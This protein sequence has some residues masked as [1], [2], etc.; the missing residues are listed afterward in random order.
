MNGDAG[1]QARQGNVATARLALASVALMWS[2]PFLQPRHYLPLPGFYSE[3]LAFA[4]GLG[5]LLLLAGRRAWAHGEFPLLACAPLALAALILLQAAGGRVPYAGQAVGATLY[6]AWAAALIALGAELKRRLGLRAVAFVLAAALVVGGLLTAAAG[7]LQHYG[8][9]ARY[10]PLVWRAEGGAVYGNLSQRNQYAD[11]L[12]LALAAC[13]YLYASGRLRGWIA[14]AVGALLVHGLVLSASRAAWLYV[15]LMLG[16]ALY[17]RRR[18]GTADGVRLLRCSG[19]IAA[20][21]VADQLAMTLVGVRETAADRMLTGAGFD[22]RLQILRSGLDMFL[23]SPLL[24]TGWGSYAWLDFERRAS[25]AAP[26]AL[27]V[28][29]NAH[30]LPL[31]LLAETGLAGAA[32]GLAAAVLWWRDA[33]AGE[34]DVEGCWL[35]LLIGI[36]GLHSMLEFPLWQSY[37]LGVAA[38]AAGLGAQRSL[39]LPLARVAPLGLAVL[40]AAGAVNAGALAY[41]YRQLEQ[42]SAVG[43]RDR[44]AQ[45]DALVALA[46]RELLLRPVTELAIANRM[47]LNGDFLAEKLALNAR[48]MRFF[49]APMVVFR[50]AVL[51][52]L[53]GDAAGAAAWFSRAAHAYPDALPEALAALRRLGEAYPAQIAPLLELASAKMPSPAV[54]AP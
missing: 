51:L 47:D 35:A 52:A 53:S 38:I 4:L 25:L 27:G 14:A 24:G 18:T 13:A 49:P 44:L 50:Q 31:H 34:P 17:Y 7:M 30:N 54:P 8:L 23:Q 9:D 37:F 48:V 19:W 42:L 41:E 3:W 33:W 5:A 39:T 21:L 28:T 11:Y 32:I 40:L 12:A 43:R 1:A 22:A 15:A 29:N 36:I 10:A 2:L 6:L 16:V 20:A 45:V 26:V 46:G